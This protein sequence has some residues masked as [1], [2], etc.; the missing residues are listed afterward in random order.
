[1]PV[2][3]NLELLT[4]QYQLDSGIISQNVARS[5][6]QNE[7]ANSTEK[8]CC[9]FYSRPQINKREPY[10]VQAS[11]LTVIHEDATC[12]TN[13]EEPCYWGQCRGQVIPILQKRISQYWFEA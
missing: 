12:F 11:E 1:M 10:D 3:Q 9:H 2:S 7:S 13:E 8:L 4:T 6:I 5:K